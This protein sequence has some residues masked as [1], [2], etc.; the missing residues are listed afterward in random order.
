MNKADLI[1]KVAAA[2]EV[3]KAQA[4]RMVEAFIDAIAEALA[5]GDHVTL[6]GFGRF[7]V[8]ARAAR[9][10]R[11]PRT[12]EAILI[13]ARQ[14]PRFKAGNRLQEAV[15]ALDPRNQEAAK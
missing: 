15:E 4:Q 8:A 3:S 1:A 9:Q 10:G 2:A 5:V 11:N 14:V 7:A 6:T 13:P 12:G